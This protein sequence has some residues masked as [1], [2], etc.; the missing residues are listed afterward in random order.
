MT[1]P[2]TQL[3]LPRDPLVY[4]VAGG[5]MLLPHNLPR[6]PHSRVREP[7]K[8]KTVVVSDARSWFKDLEQWFSA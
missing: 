4:W 8:F 5:F 1:Y 6:H 2:L 7:R 3:S